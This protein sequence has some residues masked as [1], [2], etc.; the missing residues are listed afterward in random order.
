M[1]FYMS[2]EGSQRLFDFLGEDHIFTKNVYAELKEEDI[3]GIVKQDLRNTAIDV[4]IIDMNIFAEKIRYADGVLEALESYKLLYPEC[5]VILYGISVDK[6]ENKIWKEKAENDFYV[7]SADKD[8]L[9]ILNPEILN[10]E[11]ETQETLEV[12]KADSGEKLSEAREDSKEEQMDTESADVESIGEK[13]RKKEVE[14]VLQEELVHPDMPTKKD[15]DIYSKEK[16][17]TTEGKPLLRQ[18]VQEQQQ[19]QKQEHGSIVGISELCSK[20][21]I[22]IQKCFNCSNVIIAMV[23]TEGRT[24]VTT[25]AFHL[26][27]YLNHAGAKVSYTEANASGHLE[28][29]AEDSR[30]QVTEQD[31]FYKRKNISY[32]QNTEFD[33][34]NGSNFILLDMGSIQENADWKYQII[35]QLAE[36]VIIVSPGKAYELPELDRALD[37]IQLTRKQYAIL[38][39]FMSERQFAKVKE[40]YSDIE[41]IKGE[42]EPELFQPF[43]CIGHLIEKYKS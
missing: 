40:T 37:T 7:I 6:E 13:E 28:K 20:K 25:A 21:N 36:L 4:L 26:A 17:K 29:I 5:R 31:G 43:D 1:I 38:M 8:I 42:Y 34:E 15:V 27:E 10:L 39:N 2:T 9:A 33:Q 14:P 32:F 19:Q 24:G 12:E 41:M 18:K 11:T 16:V 30:D 22:Q 3:L 23:G 35:T